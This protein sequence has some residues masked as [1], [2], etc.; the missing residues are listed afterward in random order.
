MTDAVNECSASLASPVRGS[1]E[2]RRMH[3]MP[4]GEAGSQQGWSVLGPPKDMCKRNL[5]SGN[6]RGNLESPKAF[7]E[8]L[9]IKNLG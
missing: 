7:L 8:S 6:V 3:Q 2:S 1:V 4:S 9:V 5:Q